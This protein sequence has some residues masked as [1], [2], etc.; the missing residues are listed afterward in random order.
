MSTVNAPARQVRYIE[1]D[2]LRGLAAVVVVLHHFRFLVE[3]NT[4]PTLATSRFLFDLVTPLGTEAVILFFVLSGFVLSLPATNGRPQTYP[5]FVIRRVFRIYVPYLAA[6]IVSVAGAYWLHGIVTASWWF[7]QFWSEP[8]NWRLVGQHFLFLGVFDENQFDP[9]MWS[10]IQE[11]RIS[12]IFPFLCALVLRLKNKWSFLIA[13]GLT[14]TSILAEKL[15]FHVDP[16]VAD[17]F[18]YA[19]IFVLGI[20]LAREKSRLGAWFHDR[21]RLPRIM[22]GAAFLFLFLFAGPLLTKEAGSVRHHASVC[23]SNWITALGAGGLMMISLNWGSWKRT[24]HWRPIHFLG[25]T[26]YSLYLWHFVVLLYCVHLLYGKAPLWAILCLVF[27]LSIF[28]SWISYQW[29]ELPSIHLGR[30]LSN[31]FQSFPARDSRHK[32]EL[33]IPE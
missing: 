20:F 18:Q 25:E 12:L 24:L 31:A 23:I 33:A 28:V 9:P 11:M 21:R 1:L 2:S 8:V 30:R 3:T 10:L 6:L 7:H 26:S 29:I 19:G 5:I 13:G 15:P 27:V 4:P 14:F 32:P 17:T 22:I 16:L